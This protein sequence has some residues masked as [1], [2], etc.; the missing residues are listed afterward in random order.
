NE[1]ATVKY[2]VQKVVAVTE[3]KQPFGS[4]SLLLIVQ[5]RVVAGVDLQALRPADVFVGPDYVQVRLPDPK[6]LHVYLDEKHT[7]VWDRRVTWWT[8]WVPFSRDLE[9]KARIQAIEEIEKTAL[10]MGVLKDAETGAR[11]AVGNLLRTLGLPNVKFVTT[12]SPGS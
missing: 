2:S 7:Q 10:E 11:S 4:E 1:L 9:S 5:G 6:I 8:P 12:G 3:P